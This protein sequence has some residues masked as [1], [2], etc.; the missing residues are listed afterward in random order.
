MIRR[1]SRSTLFP[2]TTLFRSLAVAGE[3]QAGELGRG[4]RVA[5]V[6]VEDAGREGDAGGDAGDV[7]RKDEEHT[8]T[9]QCHMNVDI[10]LRVAI[11]T[12]GDQGHQHRM[13]LREHST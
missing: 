13:S 9:V 12:M 7:D 5:A 8:T 4:Q 11:K 3:R 10:R 2:Y 6:A 1:A